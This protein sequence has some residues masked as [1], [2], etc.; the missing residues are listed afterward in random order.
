MGIRVSQKH[1]VNP[2]LVQC[3]YCLKERN[4]LAL[5]GYL[6]GDKQAPRQGVID[7]EPCAE[8]AGFMKQGVILISVRTGESGD[9]PYRTGG[10]CVVT[11]EAIRKLFPTIADA[12]CTQRV[13]FVPDEVWDRIGLPRGPKEDSSC[14]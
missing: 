5:L 2:M 13:A 1:G 12:I 9:N 8:C 3:F 10:W 7:K 14:K 4:E 11:S 6:P